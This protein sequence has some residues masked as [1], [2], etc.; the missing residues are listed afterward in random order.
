M[1]RT[2]TFTDD[3]LERARNIRDEHKNDNREYRAAIILLLKSETDLTKEQIANIFGIDPKTV[4]SD[5]ESILNPKETK[6]VWGG[7]NNR[8]MTIEEEAQFL[9]KYVEEATAGHII[10][11]PQMHNDYNLL[12]G[13]K[14]PKST[15][16]RLLKRHKWRK[17]LPDTRHPKGDP[18][19][20]KEFKKKHFG[21]RWIR[22]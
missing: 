2:T 11:V 9:D 22:L 7:G 14:T 20:Q 21:N 10:T 3:D 18:K 1:A 16:Y 8:L 5:I 15:F 19:V 13:R 12:V 6:K 4:Y 17:V